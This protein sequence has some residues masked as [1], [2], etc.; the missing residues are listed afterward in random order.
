[1]LQVEKLLPPAVFGKDHTIMHR[2]ATDDR[3]KYVW[4]ELRPRAKSDKALVEFFDCAWQRAR[5]PHFVETLPDRARQARPWSEAAELCRWTKQHNILVRKDPGK[6]AAFDVVASMFDEIARREGHLD[7]PLVV[8]HH[9]V[10]DVARAYARVLGHATRE[11]FGSPLYRTV[12]TTASVAL[13]Q[14]IDPQQVR[15]WI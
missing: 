12:A 11:L 3:M 13:D 7:S 4:R 6:A 1:M 10:D 8:K 9:S 15:G 2:L 5:F 14:Y